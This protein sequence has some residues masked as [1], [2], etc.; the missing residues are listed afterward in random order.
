L[1]VH[2]AVI[3]TTYNQPQWLEKVLWGYA[4]QTHHEFELIVADDGSGPETAEVL[5]RVQ[6]DAGLRLTHIWHEDLGFRKCTILNKAIMATRAEYLIFSDG[7][8]I[9]RGDFVETHALR[10]E[11]GRFLSGGMIWLDRATSGRISVDDVCTGRIGDPVWLQKTGWK[12]GRRRLRLL[13]SRRLSALLDAITPT[14]ATFNGHNS[15]AWRNDLLAVNGFDADMGYGGED[16][17]VGERLVN[18]GVRGKQL[19]Y[20]AI[21]FHLDHDRPYKSAEVIERNRAL[22][23]RIRAGGKTRARVGIS[24][25]TAGG[26]EPEK[27]R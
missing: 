26:G 19:R 14:G 6:K 1:T 20:R 27:T 21:C 8:C 2:I 16:R 4:A 17:A 13:R 9:P 22:R 10:A 3:L 23:S 12:G 7:D 25:L 24:E 11:R 18:L 5:A 15:S